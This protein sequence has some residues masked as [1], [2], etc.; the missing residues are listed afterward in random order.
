MIDIIIPTLW[1]SNLKIF[2]NCLESYIKNVN[3]KNIIVIDND[4]KNRPKDKILQ[5]KKITLYRPHK[6]IF[7][8]PAWN[9][10]VY[11]ASSDII[12]LLSDDVFV[13]DN[14]LNHISTL[15]FDDIDILGCRISNEDQLNIKKIAVNNTTNLGS[16]HYGFGCCMFMKRV[17]YNNIPSLYKIWFGD[18]FLVLN[19]NTTFTINFPE[20]DVKFSQTINSF[21]SDSYVKKRIEID[22]NNARRFLYKNLSYK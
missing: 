15:N 19:S 1:K 4:F 11:K 16:Q 12:C 17:K 10:G 14:I 20:T 5:D 13:N 18:D 9:Y 7:V 3:V 22:I 21:S 8:N 6:N 2:L